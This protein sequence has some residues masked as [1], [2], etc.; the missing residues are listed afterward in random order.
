MSFLQDAVGL[1]GGGVTGLLGGVFEGVAGYF[2]DKAERKHELDMR[3][4]DLEEMDK[5]AELA[6]QRVE[7]EGEIERAI[8]EAEAD[9]EEIKAGAAVQRATYGHDQ[10]FKAE[11]AWAKDLRALTRPLITFGGML[12]FMVLALMDAF[13]NEADPIYSNGAVWI[14]TQ[15]VTWWFA[16][17][18]TKTIMQKAFG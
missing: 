8:K 14:N 7:V 6:I 4:L 17:R 11:S 18:H 3:R 1:L 15:T 9:I 12:F 5:E 2:R 10:S 13:G 16:S